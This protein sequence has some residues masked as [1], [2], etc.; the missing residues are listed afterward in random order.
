MLFDNQK[1]ISI[2]VPESVTTLEGFIDLLKKHHLREK[3]E[4]FI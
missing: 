3:E 2:E 4:M 1:T